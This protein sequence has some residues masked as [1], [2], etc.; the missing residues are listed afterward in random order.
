MTITDK[1]RPRILL[2]VQ[3]ALLGEVFPSMVYVYL[4][5]S[6]HT[7]AL[8]VC[9]DSCYRE[10]DAASVSSIE[11]EISADFPG[12]EVTSSVVSIKEHVSNASEICVF[13]RRD[14]RG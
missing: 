4:T 8:T 5:W 11:A 6:T 2:S 9:V 3:R 10:S 12:V 14:Q 13:A 1:D 7:I